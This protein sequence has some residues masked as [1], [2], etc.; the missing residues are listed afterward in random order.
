M[1]PIAARCGKRQVQRVGDVLGLHGRAQL[2]GDDVA[3]E[4]VEDGRQIEPAPA[5]DLQIGEVGLPE[6]VGR[7]RLVLE[8]V[9]GLD[10]DEGRAGD[11]VVRLEQAIDGSFRDKI[12]FGV[13]EGHR[14]FPRRQL[15]PVQGKL[16]DPVPHILGNAVPD[17]AG[18]WA[19]ILERF[20]AAGQ[21]TIIPSVEGGAR[22][23][24][25]VPACDAPASGIARRSG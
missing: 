1:A 11:Q 21:E 16:D 22:E 7:R 25:A 18:P 4:V 23:C 9:G 15:R 2:P 3:G 20:D 24:R 17:P 10:D 13:G 8:L 5:D 19:A 6:L 12:A 14:Q